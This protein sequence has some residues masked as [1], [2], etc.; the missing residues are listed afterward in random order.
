M[1]EIAAII[2]Y[3]QPHLEYSLRWD[4][5]VGMREL[6]L[7]D[8]RHIR[9]FDMLCKEMLKPESDSVE[10]FYQQILT[11]PEKEQLE[12]LKVFLLGYNGSE[13][14]LEVINPTTTFH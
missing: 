2:K 8:P 11:I 14:L 7:E 3:A 12:N 10:A 9:G 4:L 1:N 6:E 13:K 5:P